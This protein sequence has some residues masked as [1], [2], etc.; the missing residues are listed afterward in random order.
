MC[1]PGERLSPEAADEA[2]SLLARIGDVL[3]DLEVFVP[4]VLAGDAGHLLVAELQLS[5][6]LEHAERLIRLTASD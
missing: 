4:E 1:S 2:F 3:T 6:V 5:I